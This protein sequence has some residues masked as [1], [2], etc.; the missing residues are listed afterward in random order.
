MS[1]FRKHSPFAFRFTRLDK[2]LTTLIS[3]STIRNRGTLLQPISKQLGSFPKLITLSITTSLVGGG[4]FSSTGTSDITINSIAI[5]SRILSTAIMN[6]TISITTIATPNAILGGT[7][8]STINMNIASPLK[9]TNGSN[10]L[11]TTG[12]LFL[13]TSL[14]TLTGSAIRST[15]VIPPIPLVITTIMVGEVITGIS[16]LLTD[17]TALLLTDNTDLLLTGA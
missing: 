6:S 7:G 14:G 3:T 8:T 1:S 17:G 2:G 13:L 15:G 11:L 4:I 10:F 12:A 16:L 5:G 9:L